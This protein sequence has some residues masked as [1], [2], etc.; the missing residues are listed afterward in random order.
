VK[1]TAPAVLNPGLD[2]DPANTTTVTPLRAGPQNSPKATRQRL[3]GA[4]L[5]LPFATISG[6]RSVDPNAGT[7]AL[8]GTIDFRSNPGNVIQSSVPISDD[9][10]CAVK[11]ELEGTICA[12]FERGGGGACPGTGSAGGPLVVFSGAGRKYQIGIVSMADCSVPEEAFG[13]YTRI[14]LYVD[15]IK[16]V[17]PDVLS[18]PATE[19]KR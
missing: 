4:E 15:W 6:R 12:G 8:V 2:E 3:L 10:S 1:A 9:A 18:E 16:K 17:V 7:L 14:S 19:V 5:P 11:T 13:I